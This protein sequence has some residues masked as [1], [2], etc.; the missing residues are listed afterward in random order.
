[1]PGALRT[2]SVGALVAFRLARL[3]SRCGLQFALR[4]LE[5]ERVPMLQDVDRAIELHVLF[6][7]ALAILR[8]FCARRFVALV[9]S[10]SS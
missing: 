9:G 3:G 10:W 6:L 4:Q 7:F 1:M 8:A 2:L 5:L